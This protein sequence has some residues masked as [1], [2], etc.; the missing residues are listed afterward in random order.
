MSEMESYVDFEQNG[1]FV[2]DEKYKEKRVSTCDD[3]SLVHELGGDDVAGAALSPAVQPKSH[4]G[5][6][7]RRLESDRVETCEWDRWI[8]GNSLHHF[9][10]NGTRQSKSYES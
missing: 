4:D 7:P 9:H 6:F 5:H 8:R 3:V 2:P 1:F 10:D